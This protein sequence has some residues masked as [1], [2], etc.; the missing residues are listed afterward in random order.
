MILKAFPRRKTRKIYIGKIPVGGDAPVSIQSMTTTQT[1][2]VSATV[3][4]IKRLADAGCD[5]VRVT[6]PTLKDAQS[7]PEIRAQSPVPIIADIH[8]D[9][10][11]ALKVL[12]CGIDC[13]RINPGNISKIEYLEAIIKSAKS[14]NIPMRIGVN[15]GSLE[16]SI[17]QK[18]GAPSAAALVESALQ[19]VSLLEGLEFQNFK[20]SIKSSNVV[21]M[22][23]A[24]RMI[25]EKIDYP[26]H[27]G[28]TEAGTVEAG[29]VKSAIGIGTLLAEGIGDTIRVSLTADPVEEVSVARSILQAV[30]H[31]RDRAEIIACPTCG[32][33]DI[34]LINLT[35]RIEEEVKD[36]KT[37]MT[38]ALMGCVVNGPGEAR[39]A[40]L[41]IA[42][43]KDA[44]VLFRKGEIIKRIEEEDLEAELI[45]AIREEVKNHPPENRL[46]GR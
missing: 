15:S 36:L 7:I 16:P 17:L 43:G 41:G 6:V 1:H 19:C 30:G 31:R 46:C 28:V 24:Y 10:R 38:I 4:Q 20:L 33:C 25:S 23:S 32:R 12:E 8:F 26:L 39:E 45:K 11:V 29:T 21:T 18:Y 37:D 34:D 27:L 13:L 2:D 42:A 3:E 35:K 14:K 9:H 40:D 44:A 22:I 5:I